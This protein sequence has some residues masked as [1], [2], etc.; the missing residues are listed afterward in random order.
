M[1][2]VKQQIDIN[3]PDL[4]VSRHI[5]VTIYAKKFKTIGTDVLLCVGFIPLAKFL[6]KPLENAKLKI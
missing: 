2:D 6:E 5:A 3:A 4:I 1:V